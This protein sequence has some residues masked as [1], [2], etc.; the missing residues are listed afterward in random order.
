MKTWKKVL[1][2]L[3]IFVVIIIIFG[4]LFFFRAR[5]MVQV[6]DSTVIENVD[7]TQIE[8]GVYAGEFGD[9]LVSINLEVAVQDHKITNIKIIEQRSSPDHEARETVDRIVEAQSPKVDVV[10][11]ATGSSKCIMIAVQKALTGAQN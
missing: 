11:G 9:F 6:I 7:L 1:I 8:D 5:Q 3:G 10:T 2:G 4:V